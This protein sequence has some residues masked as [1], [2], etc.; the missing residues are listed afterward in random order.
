MTRFVRAFA[1]VAAIALCSATM[2]GGSVSAT[3][4]SSDT[5]V[6]S[7]GVTANASGVLGA[8]VDDL[9][10]PGIT[11]SLDATFTTADLQL[12]VLDS[13]GGGAGWTVTIASADL[14]STV[15]GVTSTIPSSNLAVTSVTALTRV[16]GQPTTGITVAAAGAGTLDSTRVVASATQGRGSGEYSMTLGLRLDIPAGTIAGDYSAVLT[17]TVASG[18]TGA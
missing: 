12:G 17:V 11:S 8:T 3:S 10:L 16:K 5:A 13:R 15:A 6:V 14:T 7:L 1:T 4:P 2:L 9:V 18:P